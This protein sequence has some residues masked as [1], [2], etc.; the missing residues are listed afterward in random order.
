MDSEA[1]NSPR[2]RR[3]QTALALIDA[4]TSLNPE[5][6]MALRTEDS[7]HQIL[8]RS[9]N[10]AAMNS[11]RYATYLTTILM[12]YIKSVS[13]TVEELLEDAAQNKIAA[14]VHWDATTAVGPWREDFVWI[15]HLNEAGD[16][17]TRSLEFVEGT[18]DYPSRLRKHIARIKGAG[19]IKRR[20]AL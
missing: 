9:L 3:K 5:A 8:P 1:T 11:T 14:W 20:E 19:E 17:V 6:V 13:V 18:S 7:I 2:S 16:K 15:L 10:R 12:P 4:Y